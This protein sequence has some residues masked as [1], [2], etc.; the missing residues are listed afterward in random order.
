MTKQ[1]CLRI[2]EALDNNAE[3]TLI[4]GKCQLWQLPEY[5]PNLWKTPQWQQPVPYP[6][7][8]FN[9]LNPYKVTCETKTS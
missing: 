6:W 7:N 1:E 3:V 9:P 8:E 4:I 5:S 2:L